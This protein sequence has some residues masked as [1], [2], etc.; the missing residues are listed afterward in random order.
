MEI[1]RTQS[2][3]AGPM[4]SSTAIYFDPVQFVRR[5]CVCND[6]DGVR[7]LI[8]GMMKNST[9]AFETA[10]K[11]LLILNIRKINFPSRQDQRKNKC[12][13]PLAT[14]GSRQFLVTLLSQLGEGASGRMPQFFDLKLRNSLLRR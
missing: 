1:S 2:G 4:N 7:K 3:L 8:I 9:S 14:P 11:A 13:E 10:L 12:M 5:S 6:L